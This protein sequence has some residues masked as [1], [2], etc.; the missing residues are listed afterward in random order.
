MNTHRGVGIYRALLRGYPRSF[1]CEYGADMVLLLAGQLDDE[2][3]GRVWARVLV[4]LAITVPTRHLEA[5][6]QR[7]A[8]AMTPLLF[9]AVSLAAG[10]VAVVSGSNLAV[11]G[12]ALAL[13]AAAGILGVLSA[14]QVR[15]I[16]AP[17]P[18]SAQWWKLLAGGA[19]GLAAVVV[20]EGATDLSLWMPMLV[21]VAFSLLLIGAGLVLGVVHLIAGSRLR[22]PDART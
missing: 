7:P 1:R 14:R 13:A 15:R 5:H 20:A 10:L 18:T 2:P 21:T 8:N 19:A 12:G 17:A 4:D 22:R 11:A 3:A 6:M 9:A 16:T